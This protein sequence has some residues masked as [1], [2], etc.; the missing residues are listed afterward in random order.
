MSCAF[1]LASTF[2]SG[3]AVSPLSTSYE[4]LATENILLWESVQKERPLSTRILEMKKI[5]N[6][7]KELWVLARK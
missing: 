4:L 7:P 5:Q 2:Q 6:A 3:F 1:S